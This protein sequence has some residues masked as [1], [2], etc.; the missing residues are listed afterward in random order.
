MA[1]RSIAGLGGFKPGRSSEF[2][3]TRQ[4]GGLDPQ[5]CEARAAIRALRFFYRQVLEI[6][7]PW[8][9]GVASARQGKRLPGV[10]TVA[11]VW[12]M[13]ARIPGRFGLMLRRQYGG[14]LRL[15]DCVRLR[16]KEGIER[17]LS[18]YSAQ[19]VSGGSSPYWAAAS[20]TRCRAEW[21][22]GICRS[23]K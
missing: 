21:L 2:R 17:Q 6:D 14:G 20:N 10:R 11:E 1:L 19:A 4:G 18:G 13:L 16:V 9:T 8:L 5:P 22:K 7:E 3:T 23:L 15:M 12:G